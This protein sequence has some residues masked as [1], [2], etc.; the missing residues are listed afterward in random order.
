M[1]VGAIVDGTFA[2]TAR[3][4]VGTIPVAVVAS[5]TGASVVRIISAVGEIS[6]N[7]ASTCSVAVGISSVAVTTSMNG[8]L[9][10]TR[11]AVGGT[12]V[13]EGIS[14][15][16]GTGDGGICVAGTSVGGGT[17]VA[18]IG[19]AGISVG[20]GTRVGGGKGVGGGTSAGDVE[21]SATSVLLS[22]ASR[23]GDNRVT[24]R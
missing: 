4:T 23:N 18:G 12:N 9:V 24:L 22:S 1:I 10:G 21:A 17:G 13:A 15:G 19:E 20:G 6:A 8:V 2:G 5:T 14:V 7:I 3:S 16:G 11:V